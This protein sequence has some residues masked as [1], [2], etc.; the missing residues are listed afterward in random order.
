[1]T[2]VAEAG[3]TEAHVEH[4]D[5]HGHPSDATYWKVGITLFV[6]TALEVSTYWWSTDAVHPDHP[7]LGIDS[8]VT[9]AVL[10]TLMTIKFTMV[11]LYFMHLK[12]DSKLLARVFLTGIILASAVY[13]AT[14]SVFV[15]WSDSGVTDYVNPPRAKPQPPP[16]TELPPLPPP[17]KHS[18]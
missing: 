3:T 6:L 18:G 17:A 15:F 11:A 1:M 12:Y 8:K 7:N 4:D 13:I 5:D 16:P 9:T 2:A 10:L 14:L